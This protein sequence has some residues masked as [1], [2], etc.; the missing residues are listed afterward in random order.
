MEQ[1]M[2]HKKA[3]EITGWV[4]MSG[5]IIWCL[6]SGI[7]TDQ[8][9]LA[10]F[11]S[12]CGI[13]APVLFIVIQAVQVVI[14]ILP[15]S[16]GCAF[17][18][19]FFGAL[20]GFVYNY[21][22]ICAGSIWAFLVAKRYGIL[23]VRKVTGDKFYGKYRKF[24]DKGKEFERIFALLIFLP[25]A[26]DDFLCYLAGVSRMSLKRFTVIILLGKP[27]AIFLYSMGLYQILQYGINTF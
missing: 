25:V 21:V 6:K 3:V 22:G 19:M 1:F 17:G 24:L 4:V 23:F 5:F 14:P 15:G 20:W 13:M 27:F 11:L 10:Q 18:V 9:R 12:E 2:R 16:V 7:M 8:E 26:P